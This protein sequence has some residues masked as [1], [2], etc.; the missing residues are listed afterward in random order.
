[1]AYFHIVSCGYFR[2]ITYSIYFASASVEVSYRH[3]ISSNACHSAS[4]L[5]FDCLMMLH[6]EKLPDYYFAKKY[7]AF[8]FR[9]WTWYH[10]YHAMYYANFIS[11]CRLST[12]IFDFAALIL[13]LLVCVIFD[14]AVW[15]WSRIVWYRWCRG[16]FRFAYYCFIFV[17]YFHYLL[18]IF[19]IYAA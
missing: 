17:E 5:P 6:L 15:R 16:T 14:D 19:L 1:M 12:Y 8:S 11:K 4:L 13:A 7:F 3:F 10:R 18:I 9:I 2:F